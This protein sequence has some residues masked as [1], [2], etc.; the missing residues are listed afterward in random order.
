VT[1]LEDEV[2]RGKLDPRV[3]AKLINDIQVCHEVAIATEKQRKSGLHRTSD[4]E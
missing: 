4:I 2:A 3:V 1:I